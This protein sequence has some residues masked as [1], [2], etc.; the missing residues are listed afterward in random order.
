MTMNLELYRSELLSVGSISSKNTLAVL[1]LGKRPRQKLVVGDD[2]GCVT[3]FQFKKGEPVQVFKALCGDGKHEIAAMALGGF[4]VTPGTKLYQKFEKVNAATGKVEVAVQVPA[5]EAAAALGA[6]CR[7]GDAVGTVRALR[8][9]A[10]WAAAAYDA[11][12]AKWAAEFNSV[13]YDAEAKS[14]SKNGASAMQT[15]TALPLWL[16]IVPQADTDAVLASYVKDIM[17]THD[18]YSTAGIVGLKF[19][20]EALTMYWRTDVAL[21]MAL[22]DTYASFW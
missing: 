9:G 22:Q 1:P 21:A 14:Y 6:A 16:R 13:W 3:C 18:V 4:Q 17:V 5:A 8:A 7:K 15:E 10:D 12:F 11:Q 19:G 2:G 20:L